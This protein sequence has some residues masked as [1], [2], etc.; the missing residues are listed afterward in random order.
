MDI[1]LLIDDILFSILYV[2]CK[3]INSWNQLYCQEYTN[4][5]FLRL[6]GV[7]NCLIWYLRLSQILT[8]FPWAPKELLYSMPT[9]SSYI[10]P[11]PTRGLRR[12]HWFQFPFLFLPSSSCFEILYIFSP[13]K[14]VVQ[15]KMPFNVKMKKIQPKKN[16]E[17]SIHSSSIFL[18]TDWDLIPVQMTPSHVHILKSYLTNVVF[19]FCM[20]RR[21]KSN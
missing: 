16:L 5:H 15:M 11:M 21:R 2:D 4:T 12:S 20:Q 17:V 3:F 9:P 10:A 8:F 13:A 19:V 7:Y 14:Y 1:S 6:V 18:A